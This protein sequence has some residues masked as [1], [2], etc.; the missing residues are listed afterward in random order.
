MAENSVD[1]INSGSLRIVLVTILKEDLSMSYKAFITTLLVLLISVASVLGNENEENAKYKITFKGNWT[2]SGN[3]PRVALPGIAHFS[4]IIGAVHNDSAK[5]WKAGDKATAGFTVVAELGQTAK[6]SKELKK[7]KGGAV[8]S[9]I[10][11]SGNIDPTSTDVIKNVRLSKSHHLVSLATMIAPSHDWFIGVSNLSLLDENGSWK[12][13]VEVELVAYDA[14][15]E[16]GED[17]S[18]GPD[19]KENGVIRKLSGISYLKS[20]TFGKL[21]IERV[22]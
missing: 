4:P 21:T 14:G 11:G 15:T 8:S 2:Q 7:Q 13:K 6:F 10:N 19:R 1:G 18:L 17:L 12:D 3:H 20:Y 16:L 9:L 22:N 5:V